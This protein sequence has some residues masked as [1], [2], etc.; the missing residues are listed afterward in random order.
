MG[1][2]RAGHDLATKQQQS[3]QSSGL[4]HTF[5][6]QFDSLLVA[7]S[8]TQLKQLTH[9]HKYITHTI[10]FQQFGT[11]PK[12]FLTRPLHWVNPL[13]PWLLIPPSS[14]LRVTSRLPEDLTPQAPLAQAL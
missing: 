2:Q 12:P 3:S 8:Q 6:S 10:L 4:L 5:V 13:P 1:V 14:G 9:T 7:E 11:L